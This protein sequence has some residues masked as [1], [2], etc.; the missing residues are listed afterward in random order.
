M[1]H[2]TFRLIINNNTNC[3]LST[4]NVDLQL[5]TQSYLL[6][7]EILTMALTLC[8][9]FWHISVS[10][11]YFVDRITYIYFGEKWYIS[12]PWHK[13]S[14]SV[15]GK[16]ITTLEIIYKCRNLTE[17]ANL[18]DFKIYATIKPI[19]RNTCCYKWM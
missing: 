19:D 8:I 10:V 3:A 7:A 16:F 9:F 2:H 11:Q 4:L 14:V 1:Y 12:Y 17:P 6:Q 13:D 18:C 5:H 15:C